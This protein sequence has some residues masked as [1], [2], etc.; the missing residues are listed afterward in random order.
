MAEETKALKYKIGDIVMVRSGG[1]A[2]TVIRAE[3]VFH[4]DMTKNNYY[5]LLGFVISTQ[6][7]LEAIPEDALKFAAEP[8]SEPLGADGMRKSS[9]VSKSSF[10]G[11]QARA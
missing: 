6:L 8:L 11:V 3:Q 4:A 1:P 5:D 9:V 7:R 2:M 10:E